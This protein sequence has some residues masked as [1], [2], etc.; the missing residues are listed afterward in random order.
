MRATPFLSHAKPFAGGNIGSGTSARHTHPRPPTGRGNFNY[1][2]DRPP[3][4]PEPDRALPITRPD[5][6]QLSARPPPRQGTKKGGRAP[7]ARPPWQTP[8]SLN[9]CPL[10][11]RAD[12]ARPTG[13][14][15]ANA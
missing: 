10:D 12:R 6:E 14:T 4:L 5:P 1:G 13:R 8:G 15:R 9:G 7:M 3:G 11:V 2:P